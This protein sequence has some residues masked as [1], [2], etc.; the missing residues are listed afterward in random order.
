MSPSK[1]IVKPVIKIYLIPGLGYNCRIFERLNFIDYKVSCLP[2]IEPKNDESIRDYSVRLFKEIPLPGER[3]VLVGHSF[4]GI[5][6]QEIAVE[7]RVEKII[8]I[9]SVKSQV[10][11]PSSIKLISRFKLYKLF[12][13][14][15][16]IKTVKYWGKAHGFTDR[17]E[18]ELF[19]DMLREQSNHYLQWALKALS[20]WRRPVLPEV[21][22]IFQMHGAEDKTF[23]L[24]LIESP[25]A[26]IENGSH[27]MLYKRPE[28]IEKILNREIRGIY[29]KS[30]YL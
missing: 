17:N 24:R 2:W 12:T 26:V 9:S 19:K 18:R 14:E 1:K 7:K 30:R 23:P 6:A 13:R 5:V 25:D 21:T 28:Q 11:V 29:D 22:E 15:L 16:S 4:G 8:L 10:E 27:I 3:I 20:E